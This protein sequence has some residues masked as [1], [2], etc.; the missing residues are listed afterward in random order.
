M[1][2][3][4]AVRTYIKK[5]QRAA[6]ASDLETAQLA[7]QVASSKLDRL[8]RK[9]GLHRNKAARLKSRMNARLKVLA[10]SSAA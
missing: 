1:S 10:D 6:D 8:A 4:A 2:Q 5:F 7:F 3:R 9:G